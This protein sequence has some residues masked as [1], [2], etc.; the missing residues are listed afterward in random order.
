LVVSI[1]FPKHA[2]VNTSNINVF[3]PIRLETAIISQTY[4]LVARTGKFRLLTSLQ[5]P[6]ELDPT[7]TVLASGNDADLVLTPSVSETQAPYACL[8]THGDCNRVYDLAISGDIC[9]I[10]GNFQ[11]RFNIICRAAETNCPLLGSE[12]ATISWDAS[13]SDFCEVINGNANLN[14]FLKAYLSGYTTERYGFLM[15]HTIYLEATSSS[16]Q[17]TIDTTYIKSCTIYYQGGSPAPVQILSGGTSAAP[18]TSAS[19]SDYV[20]ATSLTRAIISVHQDLFSVPF[21]Q[22]ITVSIGCVIGVE[23]QGVI[24]TK[25]MVLGEGKLPVLK[26][27]A[28]PTFSSAGYASQQFVISNPSMESNTQQ[29]NH[30]PISSGN[31]VEPFAM[32]AMVLIASIAMLF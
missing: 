6:F 13:S 26:R 21:D 29:P 19:Y 16:T 7:I 30:E 22:N 9:E 20:A 28:N 2:S 27:G 14:V 1:T 10:S 4:D 23:Y 5:Y 15:G 25:R 12:T 31:F 8:S 32:L 11:L 18:A 3:A 17:V 24:Y